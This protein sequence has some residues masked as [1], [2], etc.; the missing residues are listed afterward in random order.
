MELGHHPQLNSLNLVRHPRTTIHQHDRNPLMVADIDRWDLL[1]QIRTS[2]LWERIHQIFV[3]LHASSRKFW[4][5]DV[6]PSLTDHGTVQKCRARSVREDRSKI[7]PDFEGSVLQDLFKL[8]YC[9]LSDQV[10]VPL[11]EATS[12]TAIKTCATYAGDEQSQENS[13]S[14]LL[15]S[16]C[17]ANEGRGE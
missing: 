16:T 17:Q 5:D 10:Q 11:T 4:D 1:R 14:A 12:S 9:S 8:Q 13:D 2:D 3:G 15:G 7:E 6:G